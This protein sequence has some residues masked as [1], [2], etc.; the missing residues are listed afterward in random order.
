MKKI[1]LAIFVA[2]LF[3][4]C[5]KVGTKPSTNYNTT[6]SQIALNLSKSFNA[7][8]PS[9]NGKKVTN[10]IYDYCGVTVDTTANSQINGATYF[11]HFKL[12][13]VCGSAGLDGY[14]TTDTTTTISSSSS[15]KAVQNYIVKSINQSFTIVTVDGNISVVQ[16]NNNSSFNSQ[17]I[18]NSAQVDNSLQQFITGNSSYTTVTTDSNGTNSFHGLITFLGGNM[19]TMS[20]Q[21]NS[22]GTTYNYSINLSTGEITQI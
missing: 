21:V 11:N 1:I 10:G 17:Y 5:Q 9:V 16:S 8:A 6:A 12:V 20:M 13:F 15:Y 18:L 3:T 7:K 19:V 14:N 2:I 22:T 4:T